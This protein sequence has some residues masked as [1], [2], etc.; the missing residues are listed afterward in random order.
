MDE[1][2]TD[3]YRWYVEDDRIGGD[4]SDGYAVETCGET[5]LVDPLPLTSLALDSLFNVTA[6][7][8][9]A[10]N[11]QRAAW[12]LRERLEV[13]VWAPKGTRKRLEHAADAEYEEGQ[14]LPGGLVAIHA[15]GPVEEMHALW[16]PRLHAV[17][18]SDLLAHEHP[19]TPTFVASS[20]Q[21]DP[22]RT[23][24]S[25]RRLVETLP[26]KIVCFAHGPPILVRGRAALEEALRCDPE[27]ERFATP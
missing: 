24:A 9:T 13:P 3:L 19:G 25:V 26:I 23:R 20:Y 22:A 7:V 11:H 2:A 14:T 27:R 17:F 10:A 21:D 15:P 18:V 5:V 12:R 4:E 8:L 6:I 16:L 1:V